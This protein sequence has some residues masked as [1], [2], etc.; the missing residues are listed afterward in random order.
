MPPWAPGQSGNP[1]GRP[2]NTLKDYTRRKLAK[3][4]DEEKEK[5]L[6]DINKIDQWEMG[7]G[8]APQ[9][10]NVGSNPDLPFR[11]IIEKD[12]EKDKNGNEGKEDKV[13]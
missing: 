11:I 3:M 12:I 13:I 1:S 7:E 4:T 9:D 5:F 10:L 8:K 6:L 2:K